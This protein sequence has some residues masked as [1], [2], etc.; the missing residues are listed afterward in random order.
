MEGTQNSEEGPDVNPSPA[1]GWL[2]LNLW[3]SF[4][5]RNLTLLKLYIVGIF[6]KIRLNFISNENIRKIKIMQGL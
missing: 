1:V 4:Y 6:L 5:G 2:W 3:F